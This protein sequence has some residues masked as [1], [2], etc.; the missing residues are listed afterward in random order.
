MNTWKEDSA[1]HLKWVVTLFRIPAAEIRL[2]DVTSGDK[3]AGNILKLELT[4]SF[5]GGSIVIVL[6]KLLITPIWPHKEAK[7]DFQLQSLFFEFAHHL[8]LR[9]YLKDHSLYGTLPGEIRIYFL[10]NSMIYHE[11][12]IYCKNC[13]ASHCRMECNIN[14]I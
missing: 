7:T 5:I 13:I 2:A 14:L 8:W 9:G 4:S 11:N 6:Q 12:F 10:N 1:S 3:T